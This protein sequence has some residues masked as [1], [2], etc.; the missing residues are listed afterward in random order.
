MIEQNPNITTSGDATAHAT[1]VKRSRDGIDTRSLADHLSELADEASLLFRKEI[2]LARV[3]L[4]EGLDEMKRGITWVGS[5]AAVM[6]AGGLFLLGGITLFVAR[7]IPLWGSALIVGAV[8]LIAGYL[9]FARGKES[10]KPRDLV[11]R[12]TIRTVKETPSM[13]ER[14]A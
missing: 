5:A 8:T 7:F 4:Q 10:V 2:Q 14:P 1:E 12:R 11:P 9:M 3:E 6:Y 13:M